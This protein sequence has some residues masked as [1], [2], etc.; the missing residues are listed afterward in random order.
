MGETTNTL[1]ERKGGNDCSFLLRRF[2]ERQ[3]KD[4]GRFGRETEPPFFDLPSNRKSRS[5]VGQKLASLGMT[6]LR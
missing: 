6:R 1:A 2:C 5:L 3:Y 4:K